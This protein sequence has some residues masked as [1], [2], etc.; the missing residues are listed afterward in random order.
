MENKSIFTEV[1]ELGIPFDHHN[2]DLY[3]PCNSVTMKMLRY[4]PECRPYS[5]FKS[6]HGDGV[7]Y[8]LAFQFPY[9]HHKNKKLGVGSKV[10]CHLYDRKVMA[11]TGK[12]VRIN[13]LSVGIV[14][15]ATGEIYKVNWSHPSSAMS[16]DYELSKN[17]IEFV[18]TDKLD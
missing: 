8:D 6:N 7:W 12:K 16:F 5:T 9:F 11:E 2:S 13:Y 18:I 3:I 4:H 1:I 15:D 17:D 14:T 10:F